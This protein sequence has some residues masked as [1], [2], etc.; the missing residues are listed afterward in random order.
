MNFQYDSFNFKM[1]F[2]KLNNTNYLTNQYL[3]FIVINSDLNAKL[4]CRQPMKELYCIS[5]IS[6][7]H[8]YLSTPHKKV[9][10]TYMPSSKLA[11]IILV[12][13]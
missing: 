8:F 5:I 9:T 3:Y 7:I 6:K 10:I 2:S 11:Y 12:L 1:Y 13:R 4:L